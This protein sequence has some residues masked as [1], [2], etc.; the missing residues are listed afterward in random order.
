M[1]PDPLILYKKNPKKIYSNY[2]IPFECVEL[3]RRY[4]T[5]YYG[6]TFP[7]IPDAFDMFSSIN[8]LIHINTNQVILLETVYSQNVDDL[9]VGD[10]IFWK[11][12]RSNTNYGHVG[13]V[14]RA[15]KGKVAIAQ[16][17]MDDLVEEYNASDI[18]RAINRKNSQFL[19]IK[20]LPR[21][22]PTPIQIPIEK[23]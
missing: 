12:N 1:I 23:K 11:R 15:I 16:Q 13:I 3:V 10:I 20:R 17:N 22:I 4:F 14:V 9:R 18:I 5:L 6:L 19:G 2:G 8:S 21:F 7:S